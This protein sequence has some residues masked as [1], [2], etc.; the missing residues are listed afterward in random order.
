MRSI[1]GAL[2]I[3]IALAGA[4][5]AEDVVVI[6][7]AASRNGLVPG[8]VFSSDDT[9]SLGAGERLHVLLQSGALVEL[10]GPFQGRLSAVAAAGGGSD[11]GSL[12]TLAALLVGRRGSQRVLGASRE[13]TP[14][15][16]PVAPDVWLI[17]SDTSGVVCIDGVPRLWRRDASFETAVVAHGRFGQ[18]GPLRWAAGEATLPLPP[19]LAAPGPLTVSVGNVTRRYELRPIPPGRDLAEPGRLLVWFA[20]AGCMRQASLLLDRLM[21]E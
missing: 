2:V 14:G 20:E 10:A 18:V 3:A 5:L 4:A 19:A 13:A 1:L 15:F 9:I 7:G 16:A 6:D 17:A 8:S 11:A 12:D 21:E